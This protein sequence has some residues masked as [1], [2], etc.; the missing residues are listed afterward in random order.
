VRPE[1]V[2]RTAELL[3]DGATVPFISRYRKEATGGLD[4]VAIQG[5]KERLERLEALEKRRT[6]VLETIA[7]QGLLTDELRDRIADTWDPRELEDLYL[8]YKPK[9]KTRASIAREKGLGTLAEMIFS[10]KKIEG[11]LNR[12]AAA[13]VNDD[14]ASPEE[15][16]KGARD[17]I[18]ERVSEDA[19]T[20]TQLRAC[21]S[22][23]AVIA[24]KLVKKKEQE[25]SKYRDYFDWSEPLKRCRA[26]RLLAILRG[27]RE[28]FLRV[29]VSV[30]EERALE[31][32]RRRFVLGGALD[33]RPK[34]LGSPAEPQKQQPSS[35]GGREKAPAAA[36][37]RPDSECAAQL[38]MALEDAFRR[39]LAPSLENEFL[40]AAKEAADEESIKVF[41]ENLRQLLLAPPLGPK[42]VLAIDPGYRTGCKVVCLGAQGEL[43]RHDVIYPHEPQS[44]A[45]EAEARLLELAAAYETEAVAIGNGTAGRETEQFVRRIDFGRPVPVFLVNEDG[46]SVYSA[47]EEARRE[48]PDQDVTVRGV[49]S[50][51]RRL[52]DPLSELVKIDPKSI[53]VG[54]YQ[55][56]VDQKKLRAGLDTVV[57]SCVNQVG[58]H[59]NTAGRA[60]LKYV[61]GVGPQ[62]AERIVQFRAENG[63]LRSRE[64]LLQ[65]PGLGPKAYQQCA[66]FLR[67]PD[68]R[69][70]LDASAVHPESYPVVERMA[71][72]AGCSVSELMA[73]P[74]LRAGI[75]LN[76]Y[77]D[78][79]T[80]LPTLRDIMAELARPGRDPRPSLEEFRFAE[81][82]HSIDDLEPG[83]VL[84][85]IV[86]NITRFGA[87]VDVGIK[88]DGLV[89]ISEMADRFVKD[90]AEVVHVQEKVTVKVLEVDRDRGRISLTMKQG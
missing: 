68:S 45:P 12:A 5:V 87:F 61:S 26:H 37:S 58:V 4:E 42:R 50:I 9:R 18:A 81:K 83:M 77:I 21:Y 57:E 34:Q 3:A 51:G 54:Q 72:D 52:M 22:R 1:Q 15:A 89:H 2:G 79:K 13:F 85:G 66:G 55:H 70:P 24:S 35:A 20:R 30:E 41:A 80:G 71:R 53:G 25:A 31:I 8:P 36:P 63:P 78:E 48:F 64:E 75:D 59:V 47:S 56:D 84:P 46:A 17:I 11:G 33:G 28:G 90:P 74:D 7:A 29:R 44:R 23:E 39:L 32:L 43:L 19:D 14:V 38:T 82:V 62:L 86:T 6:T 88:Q 67:V 27:V 10:M 73:S 49:V 40:S 69:Q 65:V 76:R 16:L 60:L